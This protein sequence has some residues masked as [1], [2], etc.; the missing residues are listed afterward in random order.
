MSDSETS[1]NQVLGSI[2]YEAG[3][4]RLTLDSARYVVVSPSVLVELQKSVESHLP[5]E[6]AQI[7]AQASETDGAYLASRF[8]DVFG[9]SAEQTLASVCFVL[10]ETGLGAAGL[11]M[12]NPEAREMVVKVVDSPFAEIYGP[13][14]TAVC[15][16]L[17]GI[18]RGVAMT[19]F[20]Q[21]VDGMEV[22]CAAK[23]DA[24]CRFVI[25]GRAPA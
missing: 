2:S 6:A 15:H 24:C 22:Q 7:L 12:W 3:S 17:Q 19:L 23:G 5:H 4:G 8:Q 16:T 9:Y 14:T 1:V 21:E 20:N 13:S 25:S 11:E 18:L 10:S